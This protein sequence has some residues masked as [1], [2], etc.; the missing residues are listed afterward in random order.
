[1]LRSKI[2][3]E[4]YEQFY[5]SL[6]VDDA[7]RN[8]L[9]EP[10]ADEIEPENDVDEDHTEASFVAIDGQNEGTVVS[11]DQLLN[12]LHYPTSLEAG[13]SRPTLLQADNENHFMS[14]VLPTY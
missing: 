8:Q 10:S 2:I 1:L 5:T 7:K 12:V 4:H 6:P 3:S 13:P 14:P 11:P 9:P